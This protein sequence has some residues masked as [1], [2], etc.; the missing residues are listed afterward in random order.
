MR[1]QRLADLDAAHAVAVTVEFRRVAAE[2]EPRRQGGQDAA[3]DA[4]FGGDAD[5][6]DPF[7]GV[8]IHAGSGHDRQRSRDRVGRHHLFAG[9]G[10]D[11]AVGQRRRHHRDVARVHQDRALPEVDLQHGSDIVRDD[12]VGAQQIADRPVAV[13]GQALGRIDG[14]VDVE[15]APGKPSERLPDIVERAVAFGFVDQPGAG[16]R[17]R[18]HHRIERVV[19]GIEADRIEGIA[20]GFDADRAF[21]PRG[22]QR[23]QRQREHERL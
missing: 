12:G 22:A 16:D 15:L 1:R 2:P 4:A 9:D 10:I 6:V 3:A 19:L 20:R 5:A 8:V 11:A 23:V 21:D 13:A 14:V 7:A 18:I 17:A